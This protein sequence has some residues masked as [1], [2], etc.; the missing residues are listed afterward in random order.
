MEFIICIVMLC[1]C[2]STFSKEFG[3]A[4][5]SSSKNKQTKVEIKPMSKVESAPKPKIEKTTETTEQEEKRKK[6]ITFVIFFIICTVVAFF[7]AEADSG[8]RKWS[9]LSDKEKAQAEWAYEVKQ[10]Q[11]EYE[12]NNKK[13]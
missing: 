4:F 13:K 9:D 8:K 11:K 2:V 12:K 6:L 5:S 7:M 3:G 1:W 10:Y